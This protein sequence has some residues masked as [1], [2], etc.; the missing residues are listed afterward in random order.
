MHKSLLC[1]ISILLA[2]GPA[3]AAGETLTLPANYASFY[4]PADSFAYVEIYFSLYRHQLGFIGSE[5][6]DSR[7]AGVMVS[8][9]VYDQAG[10]EIDSASTYFLSR[11]KNETEQ[12]LPGIRLFDLIPLRLPS[13]YYRVEVSA[14]DD[15]TKGTGQTT[16]MVTVPEYSPDKLALSDI[17]L[18][19]EISDAD[20]DSSTAFNQRL[21]K[22]GLLVVPNPTGV[23]HH[24]VDTVLHVYSELY[25]LTGL[26][27][28]DDIFT[29]HYTVKDSNANVVHDYGVTTY[30][31][32]GASAV[33]TE[34]LD[35]RM[36][37]PGTYNL[38]LEAA[39][40]G[41]GQ[42]TLAA[43][44]FAVLRPSDLAATVN[45]DD[46]E[47]MVNIAY[48]HLSEAEKIQVGKLTPEGK[49]NLVRQF[50]RD[51]DDEPSDPQ[52]PVY[53]EAVRRFQYA[54]ENFSGEAG[55][56][57]GWRTD[58]G[59][60]YITYGRPDEQDEVVMSG[61]SF[62]YIKWTYHQLEGGA[63]FIFVND[64]VAGVSEYR[65][66]HSTHPHEKYDPRWE[67]ILDEVDQQE[68]DW[69]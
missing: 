55:R 28:A 39:R 13:G 16:L 51:Q 58:R 10:D 59:R 68:G 48:Y 64:F 33:L 36:L 56:R 29:V 9:R 2:I 53:D 54:N 37:P 21:V 42:Q 49:A 30:E 57:D 14:I 26:V 62:P 40:P 18:A 43:R 19:Y 61:R 52:N 4:A 69:D 6:Y 15:V 34:A 11:V 31:I 47:L 63:I 50:W 20:D 22:E 35:I 23:F 24:G 1:A 25:G 12:N 3:A 27:P 60:V 46:V 45:P 7:Y 65:L 38:L 67:S 41:D 32:P 5:Q 17:E 8:A 66:V 44:R